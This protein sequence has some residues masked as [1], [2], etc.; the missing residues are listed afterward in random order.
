MLNRRTALQTAASLAVLPATGILKQSDMLTAEEAR[1]MG[2]LVYDDW[3]KGGAIELNG[4]SRAA[5]AITRYLL[6]E[7]WTDIGS[8]SKWDTI[9]VKSWMGK[10]TKHDETVTCYTL[11]HHSQV[12]LFQETGQISREAANLIVETTR[13]LKH[14]VSI[15][16]RMEKTNV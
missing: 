2:L 1:A 15:Y 8:G 12:W 6:N 10:K 14:F 9:P 4:S 7:G 13:A 11:I 5:I 3:W 16:P